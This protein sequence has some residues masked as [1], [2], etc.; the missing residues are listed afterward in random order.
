MTIPILSGTPTN[1]IAVAGSTPATPSNSG[2]GF[3]EVLK[4]SIEAVNGALHEAEASAAG[5]A[6]GQHANIHETMIALEKANIS[7]RLMTKVQN[8]VIAA[9]QDI[10]RLQV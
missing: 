2:A 8:K 4:Q 9:Y 7:F 10:M 6:S 5:L 1:M 3:S